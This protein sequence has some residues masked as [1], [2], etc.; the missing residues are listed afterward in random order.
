MSSSPSKL[1]T[2]QCGVCLQV[3]PISDFECHKNCRKCYSKDYYQR[4]KK[5]ILERSKNYRAASSLK[6]KQEGN[7][8]WLNSLKD[9]EEKFKFFLE[10]NN[11]KIEN[12]E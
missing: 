12:N 2:R 4:N 10:Q 3:L 8:R 7:Y 5:K 9:E 11:L 1:S 6:K